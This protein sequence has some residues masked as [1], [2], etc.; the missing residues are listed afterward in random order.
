MESTGAPRATFVVPSDVIIPHTAQRNFI[1]PGTIR[2][3]D[4]EILL[5]A[6]WGRPPANFEQLAA[7][8]PVPPVY[9]SRDGGRTWVESGR[10]AMEW[11]LSGMISDGGVSFLRL[12]DG[13][14][15]LIAH[16]HLPNRKG[17]ALP[18]ISFS[19]D[20]GRTWTPAK[21]VGDLEE[22]TYYVMNDRLIRLRDGRLVLPVARPVAGAKSEGDKDESFCFYSDDL[23]DT[24]RHSAPAPLPAGPRG[25]PEPCVIELN[26]GRLMLLTRSGT[27]FLVKS[28][29][30]DRGLTW[31]AGENTT[32]VSP[33]SSLT[34][35]RLPDGRLIVF[36]NHARPSQLG[37]FFPRNPLAYA[38]S[39][40]EGATWSGPTI[41]D[42]DGATLPVPNRQ[43]I[44]P[45][46]CFL[47]TG[48][49][50]IYSTHHA[51]NSF[52]AKTPEQFLIGGGKRAL[53]AY[54]SPAGRP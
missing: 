2:L 21:L 15:V 22:G 33:C 10:L 1:G 37:D 49:L 25:M 23:G 9:R 34:L 54:P 7:S 18:V 39:A 44:Y 40:D 3:R 42:D 47:D 45:S 43:H 13:R 28:Y 24:W 8:F 31:S 19:S 32:L 6:P 53:L 16:R 50:V 11:K 30:P 38:V 17:G 41:V 5:V 36:Y 4:G 35:K 26:D 48:M 12:L 14:I 27:G 20:E 52:G 51:A 46:I 29:S